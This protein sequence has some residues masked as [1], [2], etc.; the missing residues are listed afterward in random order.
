MDLPPSYESVS[1]RPV[2]GNSVISPPEDTP[3]T[4]HFLAMDDT[5]NSLSLSYKVP[6]SVLR[7]HNSLFSDSLLAARKFLL[8]PHTHYTGPALSTPPDPEEEERKNK[9]R[10]WMVA[11]KCA[12]YNVATLYLKGSDW[13]L[14]IAIDS[15]QADEQWE[16]EHPLKGK[17][18]SKDVGNRRRFGG[19]SLAGQLQ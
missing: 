6:V 13:N 5:I 1:T 12:E 19:G 9:V 15:F 17:G 16:K 3:D 14:D 8:I 7:Q 11:T 2:N 18:K 10:R 4:V